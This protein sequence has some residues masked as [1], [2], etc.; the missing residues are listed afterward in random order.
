MK[1]RWSTVFYIVIVA[2]LGFA[3]YWIARQGSALQTPA[4]TAQQLQNEK[5][6]SN[7]SSFQVFTDSFKHGLTDPLAVLLL[8]IIVIIASARLFGYLFKKI[9]QPAVIG[10]I[11]A[12]IRWRRTRRPDGH[13]N[14][15]GLGGF[16]HIHTH[17][18]GV[19]CSR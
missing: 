17:H 5:A 19:G 6:T 13:E 3:I 10:E 2:G 11:V 9:R 12:G 4:L 14:G 7:T 1:R 8:Q 16:Q 18:T 15:A